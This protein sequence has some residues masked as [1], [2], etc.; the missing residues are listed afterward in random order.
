MSGTDIIDP[1]KSDAIATLPTDAE[2]IAALELKVDLLLA[3]LQ[4][5]F[6]GSLETF[7]AKYAVAHE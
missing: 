1:V 7:T 4:D 5:S 6:G 2:R 3:Y